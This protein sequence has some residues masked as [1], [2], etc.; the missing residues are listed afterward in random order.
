MRMT[1]LRSDTVTKPSDAMRRAMAEAEVGDDVYG[2]DPTVNRLEHEVASRLRKEAG[3]FVPSGTMA[4]QAA[5]LAH[6]ERGDELFIHRD[7][8]AYYYEGGGA[9]L[10]AGAMLTL[11]DGEEGLFTPEELVKAVRPANIHHPRPRL[12]CLENTHNRAGGA[13]LSTDRLDPVMATAR[14]LGLRVHVDGAR[15]FNAAVALHTS[16]DRLVRDADSVSICLSKGLGA[17]VG[18]VLVGDKAF[19]EVARRYRKWLGGGM[20]QA[21]V[22][23]AAGLLALENVERLE[24][25]HARARRLAEGLRALGYDAWQP[26]VSTN[27]VMVNTEVEAEKLVT[28]A[29]R[30]GVLFGTMGKHLVRLVTHLDV[31]DADVDR[32][33]T[34]FEELK[35][36][37]SH[38]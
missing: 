2:E 15:L 16:A 32:A 17:P 35:G 1:D 20:R 14:D 23:A 22:L 19:I 6:T 18:S 37:E 9:A 28:E 10:W 36:I 21:G 3:L 38:A 24:D 11:L 27:M 12:V 13:A 29:Q 4:N 7:S 25:D 34:V 31:D 30:R 26:K 33:L 5:I 8:H